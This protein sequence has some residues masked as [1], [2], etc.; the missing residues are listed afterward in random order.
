MSRQVFFPAVN[1]AVPV[2]VTAHE[3]VTPIEEHVLR[4]IDA[5]LVQLDDLTRFF[6]LNLRMAMELL[7]RMLHRNLILIDFVQGTFALPAQVQAAVR[8]G[9]TATLSVSGADRAKPREILLTFNACTGQVTPRRFLEPYGGDADRV[10][11]EPEDGPY[12]VQGINPVQLEAAANVVLRPEGLRVRD[13]AA[14]DITLKEAGGF[15]AV[16]SCTEWVDEPSV[17][18]EFNRRHGL[19]PQEVADLEALV[20]S[21]WTARPWLWKL[22]DPVAMT[23][24]LRDAPSV[25]RG[26][27]SLFRLAAALDVEAARLATISPQRLEEVLGEAVMVL[28]STTAVQPLVGSRE[29]CDRLRRL[30]SSAE[31]QIILVSPFLSD[32][33]PSIIAGFREAVERHAPYVVIL[34]GIGKDTDDES[35]RAAAALSGAASLQGRAVF[36]AAVGSQVHAKVAV[37]DST[38]ALVGTKN[39]LSS[40]ADSPLFEVA[41]ALDGALV[42]EELLTW[43]RKIAPGSVVS[44]GVWRIAELPGTRTPVAWRALLEPFAAVPTFSEILSRAEMSIPDAGGSVHAARALLVTAREQVRDWS[45]APMAPIETRAVAHV[46]RG[47]AESLSEAGYSTYQIVPT[48]MHRSLLFGA[49]ERAKRSVVITSHRMGPRSVGRNLRGAIRRALERGVTVVLIWTELGVGPSHT[50]GDDPVTGE[51]L[52]RELRSLAADTPGRLVMNATPAAS[53]AKLLLI[54]GSEAVVSSFEFL[55]FLDSP[56]YVRHEIGVWLDSP[57]VAHRL[58]DGLLSHVGAHDPEFASTARAACAMRGKAG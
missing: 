46:L 24:P 2:T 25:R 37:Q 21:T 41:V 54:D 43:A 56:E 53:H 48:E 30:M 7:N 58:L 3:D 8:A 50:A 6:G 15:V 5:G 45:R 23:D 36:D 12:D 31:K 57:C 49:L 47:I 22:L 34:H 26:P 13:V 11:F 29:I 20:R 32:S 4:A 19:L 27:S 28:D 55:H 35:R 16:A 1:L 44:R 38:C 40:G 42:V 14:E 17:T 18:L 10:H 33:T 52:I 9:A 51:H 39:L